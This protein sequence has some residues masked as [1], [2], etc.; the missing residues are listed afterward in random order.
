[1]ESTSV[2]I[3]VISVSTLFATSIV[4][5]VSS[6]MSA[7]VKKA[8]SELTM[9]IAFHSTNV[10]QKSYSK[11]TKKINIHDDPFTF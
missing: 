7:S 8:I 2:K 10:H 11:I 1:M 3:F 5:I 9:K 4:M 6:H